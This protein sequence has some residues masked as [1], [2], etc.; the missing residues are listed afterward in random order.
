MKKRIF[1]VFLAFCVI[2]SLVPQQSAK[3]TAGSAIPNVE[4]HSGGLDSGDEN[5]QYTVTFH[6]NGGTIKNANYNLNGTETRQAVLTNQ[7]RPPFEPYAIS[8]YNTNDKGVCVSPYV[9]FRPGY[10]FVG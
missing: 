5:L 6:P 10:V 2:V 8:P 9:P 7:Y 4:D 1:S 3:A